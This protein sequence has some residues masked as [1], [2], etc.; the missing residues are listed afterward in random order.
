MRLLL[1]AGLVLALA[2]GAVAS[3]VDLSRLSGHPRGRLPL[4]VRVAPSGHAS[5]DTA[6]RAALAD[7]NTVARA[8]L[9]TP[10]FTSVD[11]P[12]ADVVVTIETGG[13]AALMGLAVVDTDTTGVI[14]LPVRV[15]VAPPRARGETPAEVLF[16]QVLAHELGHALGLPH[17]PDASSVM[18]CPK[19]A[20]NFDDPAQRATYIAARRHPDL[21][22][23]ERQ[24]ADHYTRFWR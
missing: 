10:V 16:Y 23:V 14:T 15:M 9:G 18:C 13:L 20:V 21:H 4:S 17:V 6:A 2:S 12:D 22:S 3:D 7:W 5:L 24:L 11:R 8:A 1:G 19:G